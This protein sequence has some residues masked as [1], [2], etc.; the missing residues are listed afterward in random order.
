MRAVGTSRK[1]PSGAGSL[2]SHSPKFGRTARPKGHPLWRRIIL[3]DRHHPEVF[4]STYRFCVNVEGASSAIQHPKGPFLRARSAVMQRREA[5][6]R[7]IVRNFGPLARA[8]ALEGP[9]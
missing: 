2:S 8:L 1:S 9:P 3:R 4:H 6:W 7:M 5:G